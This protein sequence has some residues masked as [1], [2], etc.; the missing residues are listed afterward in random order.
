MS[1]AQGYL[2]HRR[3]EIGPYKK[4]AQQP[5]ST[6][7]AEGGN[8]NQP[9]VATILLTLRIENNSKF[10]R[11]KKR[12]IKHVE[13]FYLEDYDAKRQPNGEYELKVPYD[14]DEDLDEAM[15]EL[16]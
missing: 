14:T 11:G 12:T 3:V 5:S 6:P 10:V 15:S 13:S 1:L 9:K 7:V 16:C 2:R 8:A 4:L